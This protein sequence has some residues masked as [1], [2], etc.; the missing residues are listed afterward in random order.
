MGNCVDVPLLEM[1]IRQAATAIYYNSYLSLG[2]QWVVPSSTLSL[3]IWEGSGLFNLDCRR[4]GLSMNATDAIA[5]RVTVSKPKLKGMAAM[6]TMMS[7]PVAAVSSPIF[8]K[9]FPTFM[10]TAVVIAKARNTNAR[11][12]S[13]SWNFGGWSAKMP[14]CQLRKSIQNVRNGKGR[15]V[16]DAKSQSCFTT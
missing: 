9:R 10:K 3:G 7:T 8:R 5:I 15:A 14:P 4:A 11:S 2:D 6:V 13:V 1:V 12:P 16:R